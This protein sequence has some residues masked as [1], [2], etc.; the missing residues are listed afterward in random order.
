MSRWR[1]EA[2]G[3]PVWNRLPQAR[4]TFSRRPATY[5]LWLKSAAGVVIGAV[6]FN[7]FLAFVNTRVAGVSQNMVMMAEA[8]LIAMALLLAA[9]RRAGLYTVV[10][11]YLAYMAMILALR[12]ELDLK[13][14]R[15]GL[16]PIA[17]YFLGRRVR[18]IES[19]DRI[20]LLSAAIVVAVGFFEYFLL[21]LFIANINIL[22]Y[23]IARGS[24]EVG[25]NYIEDSSLFISGTRMQGRNLLPF[26]GTHRVSSVFLEPVA[27]GNYGAFLALW[28]IFRKDM[29]RRWLLFA[30]A[31]VVIVLG[32]ARFGMLV[33]F[34]IY[35]MTLVYRIVPRL[36]W[37]LIPALITLAM[38]IYGLST[39]ALRWEDDLAGRWLH[40][41]WL[42]LKLDRFA[43]FGMSPINGFLEDNGYAYSLHQIG[44]VG[45]AVLW[46]LYVFAPLRSPDAW[47]FRAGLITYVCLLMVVSS[48]FYSI[49]TGALL[50]FCA[51][52]VDVWRG[53][54]S[55]PEHPPGS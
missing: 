34:A 7:C 8:L 38:A 33:C 35:A 32:D 6:V 50:W 9:D 55:R 49:K 21:D 26:L 27:M 10:A 43:V 14:I 46:S 44:L 20:V 4:P 29:D 28:A 45:V 54:A 17:F 30:A 37:V 5:D 15:D 13:A 40:A 36:I 51:G 22:K 52:A 48:S 19:V 39:D 16:I 18:D 23:Y 12:P 25:D 42:L 3:A 47:R 53:F 11:V 1:P 2:L 31:A 24:L 41:S